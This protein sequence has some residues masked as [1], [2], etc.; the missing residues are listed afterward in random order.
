MNNDFDLEDLKRKAD[1]EFE[2]VKDVDTLKRYLEEVTGKKVSLA[3]FTPS[4]TKALYKMMGIDKL[5]LEPC[6]KIGP[7]ENVCKQMVK[8]A[9]SVSKS[10]NA[11]GLESLKD[12][13]KSKNYLNAKGS[14]VLRD[15]EGESNNEDSK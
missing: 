8:V 7:D 4:Q 15:R 10:K 14:E 9:V 5:Y 2:A 3:N 1:L 11:F 6:D 13:L 12:M